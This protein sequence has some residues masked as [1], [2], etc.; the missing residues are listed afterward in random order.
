MGINTS[1]KSKDINN[2]R[3][4]TG[5]YDG[6]VSHAPFLAFPPSDEHINIMNKYPMLLMHI[7]KMNQEYKKEFIRIKERLFMSNISS[8]ETIQTL[9]RILS[10]FVP[11][12]TLVDLIATYVIGPM[13][14][15]PSNLRRIQA[16][17]QDIFRIVFCGGMNG[18]VPVAERGSKV[19]CT[20]SYL[21]TSTP[22]TMAM[23]DHGVIVGTTEKRSYAKKRFYARM[24]G[25]TP[26]FANIPSRMCLVLYMD[27]TIDV[28]AVM[29]GE[30]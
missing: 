11:I 20:D 2:V 16:R 5:T 23:V 19:E 21:S 24:E 6:L 12:Q 13:Y 3:E 27:R 22:V 15:Y 10:E 18:T 4:H 25:V 28:F 14:L 9:L 29:E 7:M 1:N 8:F 17:K 30:T 26:S